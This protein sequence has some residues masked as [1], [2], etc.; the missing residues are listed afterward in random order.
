MP[1]A[2]R[3]IQELHE[4]FACGLGG[5]CFRSRHSL[6]E[7]PIYEQQNLVRATVGVRVPERL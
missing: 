4:E 5:V 2:R 7:H 6:D 3:G 1:L